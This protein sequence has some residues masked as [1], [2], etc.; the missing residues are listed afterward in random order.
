MMSG[1]S[2]YNPKYNVVSTVTNMCS[3]KTEVDGVKI[4]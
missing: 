2:S 4:T 1:Y 3:E